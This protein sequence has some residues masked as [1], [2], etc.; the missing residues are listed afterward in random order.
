MA[1]CYLHF[2][3]FWTIFSSWICLFSVITSLCLQLLFGFNKL[4]SLLTDQGKKITSYL[5]SSYC[6]SEI[7]WNIV[8]DSGPV[9]WLSFQFTPNS[10]HWKV[11]RNSSN[12]VSKNINDYVNSNSVFLPTA[13]HGGRGKKQVAHTYIY[14]YRNKYFHGKLAIIHLTC[15]K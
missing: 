9:M 8:L 15:F 12:L 3:L 11:L 10:D 1:V 13:N 14:P 6:R 5:L 2:E 7:L 4:I